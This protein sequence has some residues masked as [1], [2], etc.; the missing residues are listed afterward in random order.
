[1]VLPFNLEISGCAKCLNSHVRPYLI[2]TSVSLFS[3][4][5]HCPPAEEACATCRLLT[6][7]MTGVNLCL[8][9]LHMLL[10]V[11]LLTGIIYWSSKLVTYRGLLK[12]P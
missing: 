10:R 1:M 12:F 7:Q 8:R 9:Y 3:S 11:L 6:S 5:F 4:I 2:I